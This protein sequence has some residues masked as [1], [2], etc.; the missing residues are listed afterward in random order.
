MTNKFK[1]KDAEITVRDQQV[2]VRE[3]THRERTLVFKEDDGY[4]QPPLVISMACLDPK[5]TLEEAGELPGE[6]STAIY[7]AIL[8][9]SGMV[10]EET[11]AE[12][13]PDAG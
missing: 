11:P 10:K 3:L 13:E 8:D 12:K 1:L 5:L 2:I 6:V 9:L 7:K 4:K